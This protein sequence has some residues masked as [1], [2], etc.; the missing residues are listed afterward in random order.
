MDNFFHILMA[1]TVVEG[2]VAYFKAIAVDKD[3]KWQEFLAIGLGM[4]VAFVFKIDIFE[5]FGMDAA[6]PFIG[7]V[8]TGILIARGSNYMF[9]LIEKVKK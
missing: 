8:L 4:V 5:L 6:V 7:M 3:C 1:V 9:D 2:I